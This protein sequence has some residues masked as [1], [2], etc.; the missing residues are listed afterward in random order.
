MN[1]KIYVLEKEP[2]KN[3][4]NNYYTKLELKNKYKYND[5]LF[6]NRSSNNNKP[7]NNILNTYSSNKNLINKP[8]NTSIKKNK[9]KSYIINFNNN[10]PNKKYYQSFK[11]INK[12]INKNFSDF[13]IEKNLNR[14]KSETEKNYTFLRRPL[15]SLSS[16]I[17]LK[18]ENNNNYR[19]KSH[20]NTYN[21]FNNTNY[22]LVNIISPKEKNI[23]ISS[24]KLNYHNYIN[25]I[26]N[27]QIKNKTK[28]N[29]S[30]N[31]DDIMLDKI[32]LNKF[33][34]ETFNDNNKNNKKYKNNRNNDD[35]IHKDNLTTNQSTYTN[36]SNK[37]K[38]LK[39]SIKFTKC[40]N[41]ENLENFEEL[42]YF[43]VSSLQKGK[44]VG[45]YFK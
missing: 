38:N 8:N 34:E 14:K 16:S 26:N 9:N 7:L 5:I 41:E 31:Q 22:N 4:N 15:S 35:I 21:R 23:N 42:H 44:K 24:S 32:S 3:I 30:F 25:F 36:Y 45:K 33:Y 6:S 27:S 18:N 20:N 29:Y 39:K 40:N 28:S 12:I 2:N 37:I 43:I 17:Y 1:S 10:I 11:N 19:N 13:S